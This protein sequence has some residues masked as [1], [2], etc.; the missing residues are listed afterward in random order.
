MRERLIYHITHISNLPGIVSAGRI[1]SD[2][3]CRNRE[4]TARDVGYSHIKARRMARP[5]SVHPGTTLGQFVPFNFCPR[6]VMLF[7]LHKGHENYSDGQNE[8]LH[9][10]SSVGAA[11]DTGHKW[12]FT[13]RHADLG[14]TE[15]F[16]DLNEQ[17]KVDWHVMPMQYWS[18]ENETKERR[19]AEFLV[20]DW[21]PWEAIDEIGVIDRPMKQRVEGAMVNSAHR[22]AVRVKPE[23]YY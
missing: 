14:Y 10:V 15:Y 19:Q 11:V 16:N 6:S 5:V 8:M 12:A 21:L 7:V 22:P 17:A 2:A 3:Q 13:D 1:W 18:N 9:L 4:C 23:W 20:Y